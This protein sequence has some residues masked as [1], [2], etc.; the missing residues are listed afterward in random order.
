MSPVSWAN[1]QVTVTIPAT[2]EERG[3]TYDD[4]DA[5]P[6]EEFRLRGLFE[7]GPGDVDAATY[8][9]EVTGTFLAR[10]SRTVPQNARVDIPGEGVFG[11]A[12]DGQRWRSP[13]GALSHVELVLTKWEAR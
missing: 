7:P 11:L 8:A 13:T 5:P 12:A 1:D 9:V 3:S 10:G 2:F 6:A 4:W